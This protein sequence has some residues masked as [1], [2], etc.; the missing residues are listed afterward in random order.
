MPRSRLPSRMPPTQHIGTRKAM[1]TTLSR[2]HTSGSTKGDPYLSRISAGAKRRLASDSGMEPC[3]STR[4][5]RCSTAA[6][7]QTSFP[8]S[9]SCCTRTSFM[10][11]QA[12]D[13]SGSSRRIS[14]CQ[15]AQYVSSRSA[16]LQQLW[17]RSGANAG[18][19]RQ[20]KASRSAL[21]A[22]ALQTALTQTCRTRFGQQTC[23]SMPN[24]SRCSKRR[25]PMRRRPR[26]KPRRPRGLLSWP[27]SRPASCS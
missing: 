14:G 4:S 22:R 18:T 2:S 11:S 25:L 16:T 6:S 24:R 10:P 3:S 23:G 15:V 17:K 12:T 9:V 20:A 7:S 19:Q 5:S 27:R 1:M 21:S 8:R 13:A 26:R